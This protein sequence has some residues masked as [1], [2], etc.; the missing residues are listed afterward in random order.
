IDEV[1]GASDTERPLQAV[2]RFAESLG[3]WKVAA[4]TLKSAGGSPVE[5]ARLEETYGEDPYAAV[6]AWRV[7]CQADPKSVVAAA[8]LDRALRKAGV[9]EGQAEANALLAE[10]ASSAG[11]RAMHALLAAH[12]FEEGA[13][14][15]GS[16]SQAIRY[17]EMALSAR[18]GPGRAFDALRR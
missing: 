18:P 13:D 11:L 16:R 9:R 5:L 15:Q 6:E 4:Q 8:G 3:S 14:K 1:L 17:Y 2:A 10:A 12:F 7:A